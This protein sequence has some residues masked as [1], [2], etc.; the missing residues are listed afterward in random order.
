VLAPAY[1]DWA[2]LVLWF[3]YFLA[4]A[5]M[6]AWPRVLDRIGRHGLLMLVPGVLLALAL[7]PIFAAGPGLAL[8]AT[9]AF[10]A[11]GLGYIALRTTIGI[12]WVVVGLAIGRRWLNGRADQAR[13]A[14]RL[15]LPFYVLHH[16]MVVVAA[17]AIVPLAWP[18]G[19]GFGAILAVSGAMTLGACLAVARTSTL[20]V[21]LGMGATRSDARPTTVTP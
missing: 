2:D 17:A 8:E 10:D 19:L 16:P 9:P 1:R 21:L 14:S 6:L 13:E 5:A 4:G 3:A 11:A 7:V 15:V 12:C 18:V 20:R